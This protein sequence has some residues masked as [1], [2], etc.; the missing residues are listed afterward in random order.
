MMG[1]DMDVLWAGTFVPEIERNRRLAEYLGSSSATLRVVREDLWPDD[2]ISSF[3]RPRLWILFRALRAYALLTVRLLA[4][5]A[6]DV[7]LV[8]Y[9]GWFDIPIVRLIALLKRRPVVFDIF[10]SLWDTAVVDRGL[11]AEGSMR[12]RLAKWIDRTSMRMSSRVIADTPT[13]AGFLTQLSGLP[14]ERFGVLYIGADAVTYKPTPSEVRPNRVLFYGNYVPLQGAELIVEAASRLV[15]EGIEFRMIGSGQTHDDVR[16][17]ARALGAT[18]VRFIDR[19]L[20][21]SLARQMGKAALC[22]GIFGVSAKADRV[23]PHKVFEALAAGRPVLT[24]DTAAIREVFD[25]GELL[26]VSV[27]DADQLALAI[28]AALKDP[29]SLELVGRAGHARFLSD[30]SAAP[31]AAR[32]M[33]ELT[34]VL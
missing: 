8:T 28:K 20:P 3:R 34:K 7:Y 29:E 30:F 24:G 14:R 5:P 26:T 27:G 12:A 22:L 11:A 1:A 25:E 33:N 19:M 9:P 32:L 18:N 4:T 15:D 13:H 2:R 23:I 16:E 10:V 31:Q 17:L 21:D 6:P